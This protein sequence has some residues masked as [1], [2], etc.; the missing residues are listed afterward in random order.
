MTRLFGFLVVRRQPRQEL[1]QTSKIDKV[2][3][4]NGDDREIGAVES[5]HPRIWPNFAYQVQVKAEE[6]PYYF[7]HRLGNLAKICTAWLG[8]V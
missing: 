3:H 6:V 8:V 5:N 2:E 7:F 1:K 4:T